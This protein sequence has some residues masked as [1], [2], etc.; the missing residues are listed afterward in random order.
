[1]KIDLSNTKL[2]TI[3]LS[4][5]YIFGVVS[6]YY[7]LET[8]VCVILSGI[9]IYLIFYSKFS[10]KRLI[11]LFFIFILGIFRAEK[12]L[13]IDMT[14]KDI[15]SNMAVLSGQIISS[16][17]VSIENNKIKFYLNTN[18]AD[19]LDGSKENRD[20]QNINSKILVSLNYDKD[21]ENKIKI[22]DHIEIKGKF[23]KTIPSTNPHQ[24]NYKKYLLNNDCLNILYGDKNSFKVIRPA[25]FDFKDK[26][27]SWYYI[28]NKFE[29]TRNK[30]LQKHSV[31]IKSPKLEILGGI[32]FGDETINPD[33][34]IKE[35]FKNSG[36]LH[37]LAASGLNV[38]LIYGIWW[39]I[40]GVIRLPFNLSILLGA[41]FVI[42]YTFMTGFPPSILR[43]GIM[44][45]FVLFGKLIDRNVS[46]SALI[47]FA[48]FLILLF[49][50]KM[51]FDIGFQ[52]SFTVTL[53]LII[54]CPVVL[55]KFNKI[56]ETYK[57]KHKNKNR[58]LRYFYYLVT[59][60]NLISAVLVPFVAQ[61]WVIPLQIHYFNNLAPLSVLANMAVVPF[62]G[63]LSFIGFI[64]SIFALIP[65]LDNF[66]VFI[67]D[68]I[69]NPLLGLLIKIS[70]WF[71][72]FKI[73]LVTTMGLNLFQIFSFWLILLFLTLNIKNNFKNNK[74]K[75]IL[76]V[77]FVI[78]ILSFLKIDYFAKN[79][80]IS[81][82]DV[83][84]DNCILIKSPNNKFIMYDI[85]VS[86]R[87]FSKIKSVVNK[88]LQNERI[89]TLEALIIPNLNKEKEENI[90]DLFLKPKN[91][92]SDNEDKIIISKDDF[93]L[94]SFDS[95]N[96][97]ILKYKN[98]SV[99]FV[100][101]FDIKKFKKIEEKLPKN[102]DIIKIS[103]DKNKNKAD[104]YIFKKLKIKYALI[105]NE[106]SKNDIFNPKLIN[107]LYDNN[108]RIIQTKDYGFIKIIIKENK[109]DFY[110]YNKNTMK[111]QKIN[112]YDTS[113]NL[114]KDNY[115][116]EFVKKN[117]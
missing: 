92:I 74:E 85:P 14:L 8:M 23:T 24:F 90:K 19:F 97:V 99:L 115:I 76:L 21:F 59:P 73:S 51:L 60:E 102:I 26:S 114:P 93:S 77:S 4:L 33:E 42:L 15:T 52:L 53:G 63:I 91:I 13:D 80:E 107:I 18:S 50:P 71:S 109:I 88:Y 104:D 55:E 22:G 43:A 32:V 36:L 94:S 111:L 113:V 58:F 95:N 78:F 38:A 101:K 82:F 86:K 117:M 41:T 39:W 37:L 67:F 108:I 25:K 66:M 3:L 56:N 34:K 7:S 100:D 45:L 87:G 11:V 112:F 54:C 116:K 105:S 28:L 98:K 70:Y 31:N 103:Y 6:V 72:S 61:L 57:E 35:S 16:K 48:G 69:A 65:F 29:E 81:M 49:S 96:Y 46:S 79:V 5:F 12:S 2:Y 1:M 44:L 62:I 83:N 75:L 40:A 84:F 47:F 68:L 10:F 17:D 110:N 30:I 64:S 9:I 27:D 20:F 89:K 106:E